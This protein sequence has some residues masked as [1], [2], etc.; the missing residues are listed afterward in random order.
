MYADLMGVY[1]DWNAESSCKAKISYF[2]DTF[3][4]DK[5]IL[6]FK[7]SVKNSARMAEQNGLEQLKPIF[8]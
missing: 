7:I 6:W 8:N 1:P 2:D 3:F 4:I 5:K